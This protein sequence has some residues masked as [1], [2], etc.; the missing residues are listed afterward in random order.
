MVQPLFALSDG[1][2]VVGGQTLFSHGDFKIFPGCSTVITGASGCGKST[3]LMALLGFT[4][5]SSGLLTY[6]DTPL[7]PS[8]IKELRLKSAPV[9]QQIPQDTTLTKEVLLAPFMFHHNKKF[10]PST[11]HIEK[12]FHELLLPMTL[13]TKQF[14][15]LS[16]GERQRIILARAL[17]LPQD[18]Y[19]LDEP[20]SALDNE[21]LLKVIDLF[22]RHNK[23]VI[24]VSH[25]PQWI[26]ACDQVITITNHTITTGVPHG[27]Y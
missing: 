16:G 10:L 25:T 26:S 27:D 22:L 18:I 6:K 8:V 5:L 12:T 3:L 23:T 15:S 19:F 14:S 4:P 2:L 24:S 1:S 13:L 7:S 20:T 21:S 17:L 9:F 11:S